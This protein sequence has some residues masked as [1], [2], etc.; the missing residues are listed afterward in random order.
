M[1]ELGRSNEILQNYND[2]PEIVEQMRTEIKKLSGQTSKVSSAE[3]DNIQ[4]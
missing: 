3:V 4:M 2:L 1:E